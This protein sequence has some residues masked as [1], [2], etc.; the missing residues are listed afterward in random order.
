MDHT[1]AC[2]ETSGVNSGCVETN[3]GIKIFDESSSEGDIV[4]ERFGGFF[5][6]LLPP[7]NCDV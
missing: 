6:I 2:T 7:P 4:G 1:T 5:A 3:D